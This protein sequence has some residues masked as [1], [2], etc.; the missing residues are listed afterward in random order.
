MAKT[1]DI[2]HA[3]YDAGWHVCFS[4]DLFRADLIRTLAEWALTACPAFHQ[5][6]QLARD[7]GISH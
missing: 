5:N 3:L 4:G 2:L 1:P 7:L 6:R